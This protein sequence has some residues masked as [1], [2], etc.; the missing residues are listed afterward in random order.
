MYSTGKT[1]QV[2]RVMAKYKVEISE[3]RWTGSGQE[4]TQRREYSIRRQKRQPT[5]KRCGANVMN[6][7]VFRALES[8][9]PVNDRFI[10]AR[11]NSK[12]IKTTVIHV[13][14]PTNDADSEE[15]KR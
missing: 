2:C 8:W 6:K 15:I 12:H 13:Y 4:R 14:A 3:C 1:A 7:E 5:P 10:T 11:F 9:N